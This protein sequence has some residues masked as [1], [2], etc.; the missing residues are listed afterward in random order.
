MYSDKVHPVC[1]Y[2]IVR[3]LQLILPIRRSI[4]DWEKAAEL[5]RE[6]CVQ[7]DKNEDYLVGEVAYSGIRKGVLFDKISEGFN[8]GCHIQFI[9]SRF[10]N[11][12]LWFAYNSRDR[13][14]HI[15][16][17]NAENGIRSLLDAFEFASA[18]G[19]KY[20]I[21]DL[22]SSGGSCLVYDAEYL[23]S[24]DQVHTVRIKEFYPSDVRIIREDATLI[25]EDEAE[26]IKR[27]KQFMDGVILQSE[28]RNDEINVNDIAALR[29][30]S[31]GNGTIYSVLDFYNGK[32]M[33][34][35]NYDS[36]RQ[37][38]DVLMQTATALKKYHN[39]G[40]IYLDLKPDNIFTVRNVNVSEKVKLFDFDSMVK[41]DDL[42]DGNVQLS[43]LPKYA[44]PEL[45]KG[46]YD[47]VSDKTDHFSLGCILFSYVMKRVPNALDQRFNAEWNFNTGA[48]LL[49][50]VSDAF[51][52][53]LTDFFHRT[54]SSL[55]S[56][57]FDGDEEIIGA[58]HKL[59]QLSEI[60]VP[61]LESDFA[62]PS[63]FFVG[64]EMEMVKITE[65]LL[66]N[67]KVIL[68]GVGGIGKSTTVINYAV[69]NR[70]R[71]DTVI[72][73]RYAGDMGQLI[74]EVPIKN[75]P[76]GADK[77]AVL[78]DLCNERVL[79]IID[80]YDS[81]G[82]LDEWLDLPCK[83]IITSRIKRDDIPI[84]DIEIG[85]LGEAD[86]LFY[87]YCKRDFSDE[88]KAI[89]RK[90]IF[91]I[92]NHAMTVELLAKL[93]RNPGIE[94]ER[95]LEKLSGAA[96]SEIEDDK[97]RLLKDHTPKAN[98]I[99][100]HIDIL[101]DMFSFSDEEEES[102]YGI[103]LI[104]VNSLNKKLLIKWCDFIKPQTLNSQIYKGWVQ[105]DPD[106]DL[107][108]LHPLIAD[109]A[110]LHLQNKSNITEKL[111]STLKTALSKTAII[112][113]AI[114]KYTENAP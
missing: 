81:V 11:D 79:I 114:A 10:K 45:K 61:V 35:R 6:I 29:D 82:A 40:Y 54:L 17:G 27:Q 72:F 83:M 71:F 97:I 33:S 46:R 102:I 28:L 24:I 62:S 90:S 112:L 37:I 21:K 107:V 75:L 23:D 111:L 38:F 1:G 73:L 89:I 51:L 70:D 78:R 60:K 19:I 66:H 31:Y 14:V 110:L 91:F 39:E 57:R 16:E 101:F 92:G 109:R 15:A 48:G 65:E 87:H 18:D 22:Y 55:P 103:S 100:Q 106:F 8:G 108:S 2:L 74:E 77:M 69:Q 32:T 104:A 93:L 68:T 47:I 95:V 26:K 85:G 7:L 84:S 34:S 99:E 113:G 80:N 98:D 49:N 44:A 96:V 36:I 43:Y 9:S 4:N 59:Y 13:Y 67:G 12:A 76:S 53:V 64:R 30:I 42:A 63:T 52:N 20:S 105:Y 86:E 5:C 50:K 3:L 94:P 41:K 58:L 56:D 25:F 88:Q